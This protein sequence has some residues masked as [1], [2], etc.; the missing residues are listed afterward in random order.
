MGDM[1]AV[2]DYGSCWAALPRR[3]SCGSHSCYCALSVRLRSF[4]GSRCRSLA[5]VGAVD[6]TAD[7]AE[8]E[9]Q[10]L[11]A[12]HWAA[13]SSYQEP[14][15]AVH[16]DPWAGALPQ[17]EVPVAPVV[18][19]PIGLDA[20]AGHRVAE[21]GERSSHFEQADRDPRRSFAEGVAVGSRT[22]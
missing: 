5:G 7:P 8:V 21:E 2:G 10:A 15:V 19:S 14:E 3:D 16:C 18:D 13:C 17:P 12:V 20:I 6:G 4:A 22:A 11:V 9:P 1:L